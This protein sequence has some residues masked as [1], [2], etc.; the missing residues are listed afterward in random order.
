MAARLPAAAREVREVAARGLDA[1]ALRQAV[2]APLR[3]LVG[4]D[5]VFVAAA[6]PATWLFTGASADGVPREA[7]ERF[8]A[9]EF[10]ADDVVKFRDLA[11]ASGAPVDRLFSATRGDPVTSARWRDVIEPLGWGDE[12]RVALRDRHGTWGFV[13]LHRDARDAPF[14][15]AEVQRLAP[16]IAPLAQAFRRAAIAGAAEP[17]GGSIGPGVLLVGDD[18]A[19]VGA[20]GAVEPWIHEL[21]AETL[22]DLPFAVLSAVARLRGTGQPTSM[23]VRGRSRWVRLHAAQLDGVGPAR[24]AVVLDS[25]G[26]AEVLPVFAMTFGL[27]AREAEVTAA[28]VR[29]AS[30]RKIAGALHVAEDTVQVHLKSVFRKT[31][32]NSRSELVA[33]VISGG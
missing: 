11:A 31:A 27:T 3:R 1:G 12:L 26:P 20:T 28:V 33:R 29:G 30:T 8:M 15:A 21:G 22:D 23:H 9:N 13:C 25:P 4:A 32:V 14:S 16:V 10:G 19:L 24:V 7:A 18:G 2:I 5:A 6:D 17:A